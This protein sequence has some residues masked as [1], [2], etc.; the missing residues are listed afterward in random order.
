MGLTAFVLVQEIRGI[1]PHRAGSVWLLGPPL[2]HGWALIAVNVVLYAYICWLAFWFIRGTAG[3]ERF[4]MVGWFV[5]LLLWPLKMFWPRSAVPIGHIGAF[6]LAV[7]LF[8][9]LALL[10]DHSEA[11]DS[12]GTTNAT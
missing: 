6:G 1:H 2:L 10:L 4:F 8:A 7:A 3:R 12:S 9:A 5:G 11:I